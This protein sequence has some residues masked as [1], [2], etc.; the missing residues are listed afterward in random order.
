MKTFC[1]FDLSSKVVYIN[2]SQGSS[3]LCTRQPGSPYWL[4]GKICFLMLFRLRQRR[5]NTRDYL[6]SLLCLYTFQW[7]Q[8]IFSCDPDYTRYRLYIFSLLCYVHCL[9][10]RLA[11]SWALS[12]IYLCWGSRTRSGST[13]RS[14]LI[15]HEPISIIRFVWNPD[16]SQDPRVRERKSVL[17]FRTREVWV[18]IS[19]INTVPQKVALL[20]VTLNHL[21]AAREPQAAHVGRA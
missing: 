5:G 20:A 21:V 2:T 16:F 18:R 14:I 19:L 3:V 1:H 13:W 15:N 8:I 4:L 9:A 12:H 7:K 11:Y 10:W 6:L 17:L